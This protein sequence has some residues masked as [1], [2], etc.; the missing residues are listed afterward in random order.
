MKETELISNPGLLSY[1]S[2]ELRNGDWCNLVVLNGEEAKTHLKNTST[3]TYAAYQLAPHYYEWIRLHN[4]VMSEGLDHTEML[5]QKTKYYIFYAAQPRPAIRER[6]N[7]KHST[8]RSS[9]SQGNYA[10]A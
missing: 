3:H 1:S 6:T 10:L 8:N 4:G 9:L 2:L 5:L 7:E